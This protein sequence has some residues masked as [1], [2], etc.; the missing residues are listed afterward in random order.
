MIK[1]TEDQGETH[2][3]K[4]VDDKKAPRLVHYI[5]FYNKAGKNTTG[6]HAIIVCYTV[7]FHQ[8]WLGSLAYMDEKSDGIAYMHTIWRR[9][10]SERNHEWEKEGMGGLELA[11]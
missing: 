2:H 8:W 7:T 10:P 3:S 5:C 9:D 6:I 11:S 1:E 4:L